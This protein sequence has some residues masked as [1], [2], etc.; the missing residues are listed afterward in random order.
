MTQTATLQI[1]CSPEQKAAIKARAKK[2]GKNTSQF[3]LD[4]ALQGVDVAPDH[5]RLI[6]D[7]SQE[8][9]E[10]VFP[11]P[12]GEE[13]ATPIVGREFLDEMEKI[14]KNPEARLPTT[15]EVDAEA[16]KIRNEEGIPMREALSIALHRLSVEG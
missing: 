2:N 9:A 15:E 11:G 13:K 14:V 7:P 16:L 3:L 8:A 5:P 6:E 4:L 1:R 12:R 10:L